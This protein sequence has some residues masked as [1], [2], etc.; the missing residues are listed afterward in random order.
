VVRSKVHKTLLHSLF[1]SSLSGPNTLLR[2]I[3]SKTLSLRS[4]PSVWVTKFYTHIKQK[5]KLYFC[6]F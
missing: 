6:I 1:T 5:A 4:S 3:F 2:T